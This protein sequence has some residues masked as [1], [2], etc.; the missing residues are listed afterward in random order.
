[1]EQKFEFKYLKYNSLEHLLEEDIE[2]VLRAQEATFGSYAPFSGFKVGAAARLSSGEIVTGS[3]VE[4]E[5]FPAGICAERNLLFS[6]SS[7]YVGAVVMTV[8]IA[9]V[10]G[11]RECY[12]CGVCRQT[13]LD[14]ERRQGHPIR[15]I[16]SS[17]TS[18]TVVESAELLLP[19]SFSL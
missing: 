16:M 4:S 17:G 15:V 12:P 7:N 13:L 18:A 9:S 10:P 19:F 14:V 3:N 6:I 2:L 1:M 5:V 8:A 11:E